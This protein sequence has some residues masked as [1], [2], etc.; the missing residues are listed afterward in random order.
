[1]QSG[2]CACGEVEYR[3]TDSLLVTHACHCTWCQRESGTAFALNGVI[4]TSKLELVKG[5]PVA[6]LLPSASGKGQEVLRCP[7]CQVALWS[8]YAGAGQALAFVRLGTLDDTSHVA[9]DVHIFTSTKQPWLAL[10]EGAR[11]Y[12]DYYRSAD[13]LTPEAIARRKE[14]LER[15]G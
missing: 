13:V 7:S 14:A 6:V 10:P 15:N 2:R 11:A 9:P 12:P 1:M 8:H 4:E 5:K 3:L